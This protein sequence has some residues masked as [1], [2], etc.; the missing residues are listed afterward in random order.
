MES[1]FTLL[2]LLSGAATFAA[3]FGGALRLGPEALGRVIEHP[4][5]FFRMLAV[6]WIAIPLFTALVIFALGVVGT[7]A[8]L[9]LLMSVCPGLPNLLTLGA[10]GSELDHDRFCRVVGDGSDRALH[11]SLLDAAVE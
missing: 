5:L 8:S 4:R 1:V 2:I 10:H 6:I 11:D 7:S 3:L 9:L